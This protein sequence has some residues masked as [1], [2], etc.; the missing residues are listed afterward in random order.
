MI[1]L[2]KDVHDRPMVPQID[3]FYALGVLVQ[4]APQLLNL[5]PEIHQTAEDELE[6]LGR[7]VPGGRR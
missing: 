4:P 2:G 1:P 7:H 3:D 5:A 6:L